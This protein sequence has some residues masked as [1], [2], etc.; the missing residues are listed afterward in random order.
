MDFRKNKILESIPTGLDS[1]PIAF[2]KTRTNWNLL[3]VIP[4]GMDTIFWNRFMQVWIR[5]Q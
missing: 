4:Q 1:T 5:F 3:D 2:Q